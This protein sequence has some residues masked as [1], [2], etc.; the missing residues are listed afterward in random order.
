MERV[1]G[2]DYYYCRHC[3]TGWTATAMAMIAY[4]PEGDDAE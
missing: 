3:N 2:R 1:P 4:P